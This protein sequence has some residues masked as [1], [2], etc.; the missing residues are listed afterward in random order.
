MHHRVG[1]G[2]R[3]ALAASILSHQDSIDVVEIVAENYLDASRDVLRS[4]RTLGAQVPLVLHGV[5]LGLASTVPADRKRLEK[6]ADLRDAVQPLF[7]SEHLAFVRGGGIEIGHLATPPRTIATLEG[8]L[9]NLEMAK[10]ITGESPQM[11]NVATLLE[12]P[13]SSFDEVEW[14][15]SFLQQSCCKLLLDL[16]NLHANALNFKWDP[17]DLIRRIPVDRI[18]SIHI[19]GGKWIGRP[20]S[21]RLLDDHCHE[22]PDPVYGMLSHLAER[23]GEPLTV[24]LERDGN[25][26]HFDVLLRE[27]TL[28]REA[29]RDGDSRKQKGAA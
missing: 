13:G 14:I 25:F 5:S 26:P 17:Y 15:L 29:L 27:L 18:G 8:T 24:I 2:W 23:A 10:Q 16:H 9:E 3:P 20:G 22:V 1:I 12:P 21:P 11:E 28:A 6:L 19:A 4:L 7:W